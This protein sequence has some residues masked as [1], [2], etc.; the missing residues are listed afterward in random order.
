[1]VMVVVHECDPDYAEGK[2][3]IGDVAFMENSTVKAVVQGIVSPSYGKNLLWT[4]DLS[5][6]R[7]QWSRIPGIRQ[8]LLM[9]E[10]SDSM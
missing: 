1:M 6:H 7:Y 3:S 2:S 9:N 5:Y 10:S 8:R 4:L